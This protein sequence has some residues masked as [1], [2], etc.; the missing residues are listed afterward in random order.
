MII[1]KIIEH[2][3]KE[4]SEMKRK[5][6]LRLFRN[7]LK[8][9]DRDFKKT[10]TKNKIN[11]IAEIKMASP[12]EGIIRKDFDVT[13]IA[14]I[15]E[16]NNVA[17][18]SVLTEK[19]F[20]KGSINNLQIARAV[21]SKPLL[22][23][24]FLID[25][26]QVYESRH[27][28]AN[29]ILLIAMILPKNKLSRFIKIAGKYGMDCLVEIRTKRE[30]K[31]ALDAGAEIIG[32]NNRNLKNLRVDIKTTFDLAKYIPKNKIIVSESGIKTMENVESLTGKVNAVLVGTEL[33]KSKD[34]A[35]K[36]REMGF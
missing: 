15:Y 12:S 36:I 28:G 34:I 17:A 8:K 4:I 13:K 29:A 9:S 33:M 2:K 23:K 14:K 5:F 7:K 19:H 22:R 6:P 10:I 26:Y 11:L 27:Y 35:K 24:D 25:E 18:I 32:I 16:K 31:K 1:D 21:T 3:K 20:F 30:L